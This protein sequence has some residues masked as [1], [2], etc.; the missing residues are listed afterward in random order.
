MNVGLGVVISSRYD[1]ENANFN[2][3]NL[4]SVKP[5]HI[6]DVIIV[7]KSYPYRRKKSRTRHWKLKEMAKVA[8]CYEC[9]FAYV[10]EVV[11]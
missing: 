6:P 7:R 3:V 8:R 4:E 9:K 11:D 1:L 5:E 2:D 10:T